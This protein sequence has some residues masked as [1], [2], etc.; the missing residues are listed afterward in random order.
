MWCTHMTPGFSRRTIRPCNGGTEHVRFYFHRPG[1]HLI[2]LHQARRRGRGGGGEKKSDLPYIRNPGVRSVHRP[3]RIFRRD[4]EFLYDGDAGQGTGGGMGKT[5]T[6]T[7][8]LHPRTCE[9]PVSGRECT[10]DEEGRG[11]RGD[12]G[13]E[14]NGKGTSNRIIGYQVPYGA[15]SARIRLEVGK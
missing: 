11:G 1:R 4:G 9:S 10:C 3:V 13:Q 12:R 15:Y 14:W 8:P 5:Y 7:M 2:I 6:A